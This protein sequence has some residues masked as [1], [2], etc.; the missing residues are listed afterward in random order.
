MAASDATVATR[1]WEGLL[2]V[3]DVAAMLK[4]PKSWIYDRTRQRGAER[5]PFI[6]LGKYL[7][8][9]ESAVRTWVHARRHSPFSGTV[10][11]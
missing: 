1:H 8:F 3:D 6:K 5:L 7:R 10:N 9:E 4:V 11:R 2:T